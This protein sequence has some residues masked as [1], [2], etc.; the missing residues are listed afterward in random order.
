MRVRS[1]FRFG[2]YGFAALGVASLW[3][4]AFQAVLPGP[5]VLLPR[6]PGASSGSTEVIPGI[7]RTGHS[8]V[9]A[10]TAQQGSAAPGRSTDG[11]KTLPTG[12]THGSTVS[13]RTGKPKGPRPGTPTPGEKTPPTQPGGATPPTEPGGTS[14]PAP[15]GGATPPT[16]APGPVAGPP[17]Q[18]PPSPPSGGDTGGGGSG[19]SGSNGTPVAAPTDG[20]RTTAGLPPV[21]C[22]G[23]NGAV[24]NA[25][26]VVSNG[27]ATATFQIAPDCAGIAVSL[28]TYQASTITPTLFKTVSDSFNAGGPYTLSAAVPACQFEADLTAGNVTLASASGGATCAPPP[29]PPS[30]PP[31]PPTP[32]PPAFDNG[33]EQG[34]HRGDHGQGSNG[35]NDG[36]G[37]G[38]GDDHHGHGG[39]S[40]GDGRKGCP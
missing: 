5:K 32:Q 19:S 7:R 8:S 3:V 9:T 36:S 22:P 23:A 31:P 12:R 39:S 16:S 35:G 10:K 25:S 33:N 18:T 38:D 29:P 28:G 4:Y 40:A 2:A 37:S 1:G 14:P 17:V 27:V 13:A 15:A 26:V 34:D 21:Q 11:L 20:G 6:V 24:T 30:A